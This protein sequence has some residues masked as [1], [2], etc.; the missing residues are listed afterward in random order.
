MGLMVFLL[1]GLLAG[2]M[3]SR[4]MDVKG[5][6][7]LGYM[8]VGVVGAFLGSYLL[9]F[10]GALPHNAWS[11]DRGGAGLVGWVISVL[12][13][14]LGAVVLLVVVKLVKKG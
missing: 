3:A 8:A 13:A 9:G 11:G 12:V 7:I 6:G 1:S 5:M 14:V 4:L 2:Y 10:L